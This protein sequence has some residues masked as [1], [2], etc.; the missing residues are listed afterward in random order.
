MKFAVV[1]LLSSFAL[2]Q[3]SSITS[4]PCSPIAPD[5]TGNITIKCTGLSPDQARSLAGIPSLINKILQE[6]KVATAEIMSRLSDCAEGVKQARHGIYSGYDF[7]GGKRDQRPGDVQLI[8]GA[9]TSVFQQF[10]DLQQNQRW[11]ELLDLAEGQIIK[12]PDWLTPYLFSG[13]ANLNLGNR[14]AGIKRLKYVRSEGEGNP[15]YADAARILSQL[16]Q[17]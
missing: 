10:L 14:D 1:L 2:A 16:G 8:V 15:D 6:Q 13:I 11:R 17:N 5:N 12:T 4:G 3:Q 9:E 7:N